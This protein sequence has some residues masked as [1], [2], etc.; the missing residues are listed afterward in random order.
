[1]LRIC[2]APSVV[3]I[4]VSPASLARDD[5]ADSPSPTPREEAIEPKNLMLHSLEKHAAALAF[6]GW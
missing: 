4:M 5:I 6:H 3:V 1:M 2:F